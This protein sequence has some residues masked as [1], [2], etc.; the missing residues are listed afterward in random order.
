MCVLCIYVFDY[1]V[2]YI[3]TLYCVCVFS[4]CACMLCVLLYV[5][6]VCVVWCSICFGY[7][8]IVCVV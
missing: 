4:A 6:H 8:C 3:F 5:L 7:D 1:E 2:L